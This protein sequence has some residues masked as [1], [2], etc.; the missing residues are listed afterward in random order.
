[1]VV[2]VYVVEMLWEWGGVCDGDV[3]LVVAV[4]EVD[5]VWWWLWWCCGGGGGCGG[6]DVVDVDTCDGVCVCV[7]LLCGC[8]YVRWCVCGRAV[9]GV[10][11]KSQLISAWTVSVFY[12]AQQLAIMY[13]MLVVYI[14]TY[15]LYI[16]IY[17]YIPIYL[18]VLIYSICM[19]RCII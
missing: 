9:V 4:V 16:H 6:G 14:I 3:V 17:I 12:N 11:I 1:M 13:V 18:Y 15:M 5:S 19:L 7:M 10:A 8:R 2:V